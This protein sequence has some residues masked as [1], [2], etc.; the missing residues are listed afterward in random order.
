IGT[1]YSY[2]GKRWICHTEL[3]TEQFKK[4][5]TKNIDHKDLKKVKFYLDYLPFSITN[6][7]P[8]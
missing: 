3:S 8:F 4:M 7:I 1:W 5:I 6:E 2:S